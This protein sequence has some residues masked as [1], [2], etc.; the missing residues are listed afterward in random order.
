M[1]NR[2]L[3][4]CCLKRVPALIETNTMR[5]SGYLTSVRALR[6][7]PACQAS[8]FHMLCT[9]CGINTCR[10]E[11]PR[12][13]SR[14]SP[15]GGPSICVVTHCV[16][17]SLLLSAK[18][19]GSN[20]ASHHRI[21]AL[22]KRLQGNHRNPLPQG[23]PER[24]LVRAITTKPEKHAGLRGFARTDR[25]RNISARFHGPPYIEPVQPSS[26]EVMKRF[27]ALWVGA[28]GDHWQLPPLR[29]AETNVRQ[30]RKRHNEAFVPKPGTGV[31]GLVRSACAEWH[32]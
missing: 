30:Q 28:F 22:G 20:G 10:S 27:P 18:S 15:Y 3:V 25:I 21:V 32:S 23:E 7:T 4:L 9:S 14:F 12:C 16:A 2:A 17:I 8:S 6:A 11:L 13:G 31:R 19:F 29:P 1:A 24:V 5:R 26:A